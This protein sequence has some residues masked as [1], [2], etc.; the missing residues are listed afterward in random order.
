MPRMVSMGMGMG[1]GIGM[2]FRNLVK[3]PHPDLGGVA[4]P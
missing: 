2:G 3:R 4:S 1:M